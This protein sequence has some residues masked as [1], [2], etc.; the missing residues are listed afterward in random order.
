[1]KQVPNHESDIRIETSNL[2]QGPKLIQTA[3]MSAA[4]IAT[5]TGCREGRALLM[6]VRKFYSHYID[7]CNVSIYAPCEAFEF[8]DRKK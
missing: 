7:G 1:M 5:G 3:W 8:Q 2:I 6:L 4:Y